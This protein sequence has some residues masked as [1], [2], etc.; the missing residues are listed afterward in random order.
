LTQP[1]LGP[2]S[3]VPLGQL[4]TP[5]MQVPTPHSRPHVPQL[6]GSVVVAAQPIAPPQSTCPDPQ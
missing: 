5:E 6:F 4:H 3:W 2:Q 1:A